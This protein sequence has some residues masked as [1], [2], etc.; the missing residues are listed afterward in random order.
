[1]CLNDIEIMDE[2]EQE[3]PV[4][5]LLRGPIFGICRNQHRISFFQ[6]IAR[7][8]D[9]AWHAVICCPHGA[10]DIAT[11]PAASN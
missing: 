5:F 11:W 4:A 3:I 8:R 7:G 1:M 9:D 2:P 6:S 10:G